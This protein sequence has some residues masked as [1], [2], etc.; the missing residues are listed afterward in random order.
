MVRPLFVGP[1]E[2]KGHPFTGL[3]A[4]C[5]ERREKRIFNVEKILEIRA[6]PAGDAATEG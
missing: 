3:E 2:Y 1:M 6:P 4:F 5:L